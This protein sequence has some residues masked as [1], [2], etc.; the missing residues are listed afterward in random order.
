LLAVLAFEIAPGL[1]AHRGAQQ[2]DL[3]RYL[4]RA[5]EADLYLIHR[6]LAVLGIRGRAHSHQ[7]DAKKPAHVVST[8]FPL[9]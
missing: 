1:L 9:T 4:E 6:A 8:T 3:E 7:E 2:L 5:L